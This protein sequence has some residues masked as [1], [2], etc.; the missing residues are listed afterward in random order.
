MMKCFIECQG[1]QHYHPIELFGG[2]KQFQIQKVHDRLKRR[3]AEWLGVPLLEI[4]Y[5]ED[6]Y[7]S[8]AKILKLHNI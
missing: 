4:S 6:S 7:E 8:V 2:E 1:Q 3:H 5:L